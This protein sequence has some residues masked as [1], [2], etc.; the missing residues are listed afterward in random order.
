MKKVREARISKKES[1]LNT[2]KMGRCPLSLHKW[3]TG[4]ELN[5]RPNPLKS[6]F[7]KVRIDLRRPAGAESAGGG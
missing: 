4:S 3:G 5:I 2:R 6:F 1:V 7:L